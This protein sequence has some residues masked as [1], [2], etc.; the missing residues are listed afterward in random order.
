MPTRAGIEEALEEQIVGDGIDG[1]DA[2]DVGDDGVGRRATAGAAD[3]T[4]AGEAHDIP[5]A[6]EEGGQPHLL[7]DGELVRQLI[8]DLRCQRLV[9]TADTFLTEGVEI[10]KRGLAIGHGEVGRPA[11]DSEQSEIA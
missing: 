2:E 4:L 8:A 10:G 3:S 1:G 11:G 5:D 6:E 7:D 9:E